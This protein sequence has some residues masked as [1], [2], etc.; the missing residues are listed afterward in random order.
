MK[1]RRAL[2]R[3]W[4]SSPLLWQL[5]PLWAA[6]ARPLP[7]GLHQVRGDVRVNGRP[8][9]PGRVILPG[10]TVS[11]GPGSEAVYSMGA[12][13][14][15]VREN[16]QVG[17]SSDGAKAVL[18]VISGKVLSVFGPGP[19]ELQTATA[20]AG[21]RGTACYIESQPGLVYFCLCYG[22]VELV[23]LADPQR[24]QVFETRYHDRPF[25]ISDRPGESLL[26]SGPVINHT[27][28][29]LIELETLVGRR[30]PFLDQPDYEQRY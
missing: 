27:D 7:A 6:G 19:R 8:A 22:R 16:S 30:P 15:R 18:R 21:I 11:T 4:V 20:T 5:A 13:A 12:D 2:I 28:L 17:H 10:D 14:Y 29:E 24:V 1:L 25:Y 23:P 26:R 3:W 9:Q